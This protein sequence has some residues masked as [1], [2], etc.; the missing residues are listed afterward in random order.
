M[1]SRKYSFIESCANI[2]IGYGIAVMAQIIIFP[3]FNIHVPLASNL[4]IGACFTVVSLVRSYSLRRLF[5][6]INK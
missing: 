4:A 2:A 3:L 6:W 5:N 1:Q